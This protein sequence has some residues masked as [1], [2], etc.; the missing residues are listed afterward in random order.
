M[1]TKI[2]GGLAIVILLLV[3]AFFGTVIWLLDD[4]DRIRTI[5][6]EAAASLQTI[7]RHD[8]IKKTDVQP[9]PNRKTEDDAILRWKKYRNSLAELEIR[10]PQNWSLA[11]AEKKSDNSFLSTAIVTAEKGDL[12][13]INP[14]ITINYYDSWNSVPLSK[15]YASLE[16]YTETKFGDAATSFTIDNEPSWFIAGQNSSEVYTQHNGHAYS[17]IFPADPLRI[18]ETIDSLPDDEKLFLQGIRFVE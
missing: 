1:N 10:V 13:K 8:R 9:M 5:T 7:E 15:T 12:T 11:I 17:I 2:P 16:K 18:T 6:T 4:I 3:T 14:D